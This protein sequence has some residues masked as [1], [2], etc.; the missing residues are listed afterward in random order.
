MSSITIRLPESIHRKARE[1]AKA[2][3]I[4]LNQFISS[5]VG[6]KLSSVLTVEYL[7]KRA[8]SGNAEH[9]DA[10]LAKVSD[11]EPLQED[12]L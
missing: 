1:V 10:V 3:G 6:E 2:D 7:S 8:K 4:S 5:A 9:F 11:R 12:A